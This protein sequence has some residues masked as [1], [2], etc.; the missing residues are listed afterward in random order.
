MTSTRLGETAAKLGYVRN[1][2]VAA[3]LNTRKPGLVP[4]A[5]KKTV[6]AHNQATLNEMAKNPGVKGDLMRVR[7]GALVVMLE[8]INLL[9]KARQENLDTQ[10]RMVLS[11]AILGMTGACV[12]FWGYGY[13]SARSVGGLAVREAAAVH[14][15]RV[16]VVGIGL[17]F[18]T[19]GIMGALD[20]MRGGEAKERGEEV[21]GY[22]LYVRGTVQMAVTAVGGLASFA[23]TAQYWRY[24]SEVKWAESKILRTATGWLGKAAK[25]LEVF[26]ALAYRISYWGTVVGIVVDVGL[27][28]YYT[29]SDNLME[30]WCRRSCFRLLEIP[31]AEQKKRDEEKKGGGKKEKDEDE[32]EE[33]GPY[34]NANEEVAY[35]FAVFHA[36]EGEDED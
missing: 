29:F 10:E 3:W 21:L 22:A 4:G 2:D 12:D 32:E 1:P 25:F 36:I 31:E 35:L 18:A 23:D 6:P 20:Y 13:R 14:Y 17:A 34:A 26:K 16:K 7:T 28:A 8:A 33:T 19:S 24:L 9:I 30:K 5:L 15:G 11:A 27:F